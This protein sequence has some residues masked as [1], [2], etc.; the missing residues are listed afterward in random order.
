MEQEM[1]G[2]ETKFYV[3]GM[4]CDGCIAK[5]REALGKLPG[6]EESE[7]DL[8][9]GT[10]LVKGDIDPQA[11]AFALSEVGYPAVVKSD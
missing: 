1:T 8:K 4:K 9:A 10:A 2:I 6:Y 7:F 11:A 3:Q 5:A